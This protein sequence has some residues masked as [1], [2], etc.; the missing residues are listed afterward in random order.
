MGERGR[1]RVAEKNRALPLALPGSRSP[2]LVPLKHGKA[3]SSVREEWRRAIG[4]PGGDGVFCVCLYVGPEPE[5]SPQAFA[6]CDDREESQTFHV[7]P[8]SG[9]ATAVVEGGEQVR[10]VVPAACW[11]G[12]R[13]EGVGEALGRRDSC[14]EGGSD[15]SSLHLRGVSR[16]VCPAEVGDRFTWNGGGEGRRARGGRRWLFHVKQA[17]SEERRGGDA[18]ERFT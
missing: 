18:R 17:R 13:R 15:A 9:L 1:G 14:R 3:A 4:R 2:T 6:A 10:C 7:K 5:D 16:G 8:G 11:E 12:K